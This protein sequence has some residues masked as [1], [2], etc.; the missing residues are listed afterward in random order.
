MKKKVIALFAFLALVVMAVYAATG[1][2]Y[3]TPTGKKY[4][5]RNCRTLTRSKTVTELTI[6][7]AKA[8]GYEPCKVC[9][10]VPKSE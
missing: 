10:P 2:V 9:N 1:S 8:K 6:E 7:Q 3:V 5:E 4:H